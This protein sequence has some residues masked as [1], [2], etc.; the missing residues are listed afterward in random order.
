[1]K[2]KFVGL[3]GV[4]SKGML[5]TPKGRNLFRVPMR[6]AIAIQK[7]QHWYARKTWK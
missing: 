3:M 4:D 6:C 7:T 2:V 5:I 1:M